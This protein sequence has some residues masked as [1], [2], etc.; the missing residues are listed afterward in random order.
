MAIQNLNPMAYITDT[1]PVPETILDA[2]GWFATENGDVTWN[3]TLG[4]PDLSAWFMAQGWVITS[5]MRYLSH[6]G[7]TAAEDQY[8]IRVTMRRRKLQSERVLKDMITEFTDAYNEG[9]EINDRRYDELVS[10]Y[11]LLLEN[12]ENTIATITDAGESYEALIQEIIDALPGD[13]TTHEGIVSGIYDDYGDSMRDDI[14]TRFDNELTK[15]RSALVDRGLYN[16]TLWTTQSAGIELQRTKALTDL[17]DKLSD[18]KNALQDRL[19]Q[20]KT[21]MRTQMLAAYQRLMD[22]KKDSPT[23]RHLEVR[24]TVFANML[25]FMERRQDDY[26]GIDGLANIAA[27]LGYGEGGTVMAPNN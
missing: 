17:E 10:L 19:Y 23:L 6:R 8:S 16:T 18:K 12:T 2:S 21:N 9:R 11:N 1:D 15:A 26:P 27:Q 7:A 24:N 4:D 25:A 14:N 5:R 3:E 22:G 20:L 13:F